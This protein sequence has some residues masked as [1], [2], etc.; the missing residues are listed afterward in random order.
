MIHITWRLPGLL[1]GK[2]GEVS[3]H[4]SPKP[5]E[6]FITSFLVKPENEARSHLG[7]LAGENTEFFCLL[8]NN[9]E[10][11]FLHDSMHGLE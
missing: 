1:S 7:Y 9:Y 6:G 2:Y 3:P 4:C 8:T 5:D 10:P 11:F